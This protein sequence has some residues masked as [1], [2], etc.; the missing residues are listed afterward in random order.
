METKRY[1][2]PDMRL[3]GKT[4]TV[5]DEVKIVK[6]LFGSYVVAQFDDTTLRE[7]IDWHSYPA[8]MFINADAEYMTIEA[9]RNVQHIECDRFTDSLERLVKDLQDSPRSLHYILLRLLKEWKENR[10]K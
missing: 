5:C 3:Y 1:I 4:A 9:L 6:D 2:G 10:R 7:S 8:V